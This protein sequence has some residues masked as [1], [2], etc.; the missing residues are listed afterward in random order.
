[1][2]IIVDIMIAIEYLHDHKFIY[3]DLKPNNVMIDSKG[4]VVLIDFDRMIMSNNK[5]TKTFSFYE[6]SAPESQY[7]NHKIESDIYS[8]GITIYVVMTGKLPFKKVDDDTQFNFE[9]IPDEI[10]NI[11]SRCTQVKPEDRPSI[12]E[13]IVDFYIYYYKVYKSDLF[14]SL[15]LA[16]S[17]SE[18]ARSQ[19]ELGMLHYSGE[20][21]PKNDR[22][23]SLLF[24][25]SA[26]QNYSKAQRYLGLMYYKGN[27]YFKKDTRIA[28]QYFSLSSSK[29]FCQL[30]E[31]ESQKMEISFQDISMKIQPN[32][33]FRI[34][35]LA[36]KKMYTKFQ[37][38]YLSLD[39]IYSNKNIFSDELIANYLLSILKEFKLITYELFPILP[40]SDVIP[41]NQPQTYILFEPWDHSFIFKRKNNS[42][43][44]DVNAVLCAE[45]NCFI[46]ESISVSLISNILYSTESALIN[47]TE[48][49]GNMDNREEVSNVIFDTIPSQGF[50]F[51]SCPIETNYPIVSYMIRRYFY[52]SH[53]FKDPS[54]FLFNQRSQINEQMK[55][56]KD[57]EIEDQSTFKE[58]EFIVLR[59]LHESSELNYYLVLHIESLFIFV[60]KKI[61]KAGNFDN[62]INISSKISNQS[63]T[64]FYGFLKQDEQIIGFIY[65]FMSNG[66]MNF[67]SYDI[68]E[69]YLHQWIIEILQGIDYLHSQFLFHA[70]LDPTTILIDHD[71]HPH[72]SDFNSIQ[73][74]EKDDILYNST[75][76]SI[77]RFLQQIPKMYFS[78]EILNLFQ[79]C[80]ESKEDKHIQ[81]S[82]MK[83][84]ITKEAN[85]SNASKVYDVIESNEKTN[86]NN[87]KTITIPSSL[88][89]V[90]ESKYER[91]FYLEEIIFEYP[92]SVISIKSSAFNSCFS[93]TKITLPSSLQIIEES[94]FEGCSALTQIS[95]PSSVTKIRSFAFYQC[96]MLVKIE[97]PSTLEYL[98]YSAFEIC[99]SLI[100]VIIPS[101]NAIQSCTY[102]N[103][104]SL[105]KITISSSVTSIGISAFSECSS[106]AQITIPTSVI[107]I[108]DTSF[109]KCSSLREIIIPSSVTSIGCSAFA[110]CSSLTQITIPSSVT[111]IKNST[112]VECS[113][114][115]HIAIPSSVTS[116][117]NY[118]FSKCSSLREI[119][120]P[121]SVTSIGSFAFSEC[122]S[123]R[124]IIIP[125]SVTSIEDSAFAGC[126][127]LTQITISSSVTSIREYTFCGSSMRE[128]IIPSSVTSIEESAF[129]GCSSLT[130]ITI[131][132][133]VTSIGRSAFSE[134][135][136][137]REITIPSSVTSIEESAFA[138]CSSLTQ[139]K[140]PSSVTSIGKNIFDGC[141]SFNYA[142]EFDD[143]SFQSVSMSNEPNKNDY[144]NAIIVEY[145]N[146]YNSYYDYLKMQLQKFNPEGERKRA[147]LISTGSFC[148]IHKGHLQLID[149]AAIFLSRDHNIDT[150]VGIIS[151]ES[152]FTVKL[153]YG[154]SAIPFEQR[155][156]MA[157]LACKEHN[158]QETGKDQIVYITTD[159]F[160]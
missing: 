134:C 9:G 87:F 122:S 144:S 45:G 131:P 126:Q 63:L 48:K 4:S 110:E 16:L 108:G 49:S 154:Q 159:T 119:T 5:I 28:Y 70:N 2:R 106:L 112:F 127:S 146:H 36:L 53:Y 117:G 135:S 61:K 140:I 23:A 19:C 75:I 3:R 83:E 78:D 43:D 74:I 37:F 113:S 47:L 115:A 26:N 89:S 35:N 82:Q 73:S 96:K 92:S 55:P 51:F 149:N 64:K 60:M 62:E 68:R 42:S 120:I 98:G 143:Q 157:N 1:M 102:K 133:S 22:K 155:Y 88:E 34:Q 44:S 30:I 65:E 46:I 94:A 14:D 132:S 57:N 12:T 114:L 103:C 153:K 142:S 79:I 81:Y 148:P 138:G 58:E 95:I 156:E 33:N 109:Y 99:P 100:K 56:H 105:S 150:L 130:K 136:S 7:G 20:K 160:D 111:S 76:L 80:F 129:A 21:I 118:A 93:L 38:H 158:S 24:C 32:I 69:K 101:I 67:N 128:I 151:P 50:Y 123:L 71:F 13:L 97:I 8:L 54:F 27:D 141:S 39:E 10:K 139:I 121:S 52:P 85:S 116:I 147:I 107:S 84:M 25:L 41:V 137:L 91:C 11:C 86:Q 40:N 152:D 6:Y 145:R 31:S 17:N 29:D 18:N 90:C 104:S 77:Q 124:E 59:T 125:S 15:I 66:K 72:I